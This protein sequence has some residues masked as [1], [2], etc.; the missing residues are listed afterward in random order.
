M[1]LAGAFSIYFDMVAH[2]FLPGRKHTYVLKG[3]FGGLEV[4]LIPVNRPTNIMGK[5]IPYDVSGAG[6][7]GFRL[8]RVYGEKVATPVSGKKSQMEKNTKKIKK[9]KNSRGQHHFTAPYSTYNGWEELEKL[10][11]DSEAFMEV[12]DAF[13][14][15]EKLIANEAIIKPIM[16]EGSRLSSK[17]FNHEEQA[18]PYRQAS[19]R[20]GEPLVEVNPPPF[21]RAASKLCDEIEN[22]R[23]MPVSTRGTPLSDITVFQEEIACESPH[24]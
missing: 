14:A 22:A 5:D 2:Q 7:Y 21:F 1:L 6:L 8:T 23:S 16:T 11:E 12:M 18:Q 15:A 3:N 24:T 9:T 13:I 17:K 19:Y 10:Q 4:H 20:L